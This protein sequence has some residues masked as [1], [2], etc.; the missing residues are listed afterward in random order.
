MSAQLRLRTL[1][2]LQLEHDGV[3]VGGG[4]GRRRPL[5]L[6]A[7]VAL[8]GDAG[9]TRDAALATFWPESSEANARNSLK[10]VV[11]GLRRDLGAGLFTGGATTLR[12]DRAVLGV[13]ALDFLDAV[14]RDEHD[15]AIALYGGAFLD[16]IALHG[17]GALDAWIEEHRS[18]F[19]RAC[20]HA[21]EEVAERARRRGDHLAAVQAW[22]R[23][24]AME[25]L[26]ARATI[27]LVR[28]LRDAGDPSAALDQCRVHEVLV[29]QELDAAPDPAVVAL[30]AEIRAQ[31]EHSAAAER[32]QDGPGAAEAG[33]VPHLVAP[34]AGVALSGPALTVGPML[35][36]SS[37]GVHASAPKAASRKVSRWLEPLPRRLHNSLMIAG[38]LTAIALPLSSRRAVAKAPA[39][40]TVSR[41]LVA[42]LPFAVRGQNGDS[43]RIGFGVADLLSIA[44]HGAGR[45]RSVPPATLLPVVAAAGEDGFTVKDA[46]RIAAYF[47]AARYVLGEVVRDGP[48]LHVTA[49]LHDRRGVVLSQASADGMVGQLGQVTDRLAITLLAQQ[50]LSPGERLA[51]VA[52]SSTSSLPALKAWLDGEAAYGDHRYADAVTAFQSA[53]ADDPGFALALYRLANALDLL[54]EA[55]RADSIAARAAALSGRL[56]AAERELLIAWR[57]A[58]AGNVDEAERLFEALL[59]DEPEHVEGW[60]RLGELQFHANPARGRS[61]T[62]ARRA[63]EQVLRI[64]PGHAEAVVYLA[65]IA[66][67][68]RRMRD[69]DSLVARA[70]ALSTDGHVL[71][72]RAVRTFALG[73]G[74]LQQ[75]A[76]RALLRDPRGAASESAIDVAIYR[77]DVDGMRAFAQTLLRSEPS[78]EVRV[79]AL[80]LEALAAA[81]HGQTAAAESIL[82]SMSALDPASAL[83]LRVLLRAQPFLQAD[84]AGLRDAAARIDAWPSS[85]GGASQDTSAAIA[86]RHHRRGLLAALAG[87]DATLAR[88][89]AVLRAAAR[90]PASRSAAGT[91]AASLSARAALRA[92]RPD[93][94]LRALDIARLVP[95]RPQLVTTEVGD[96][97]LR[98]ELLHQLGRDDEAEGW[99]S[100]IA[101]RAG[102][103]LPWLAPAQL[104]LG[105]IHERRG[106]R[107]AALTHY[108]RFLTLWR[109]CDRE[110]RPVRDSVA[111]T[112]ARLERDV[113]SARGH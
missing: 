44:L 61:V 67:L 53:V 9:V 98:A 45:L 107:D 54:G 110:L 76:L 90:E 91:L 109:D 41:S 4:A 31:L 43:A 29:R 3:A 95:L 21:L 48:R 108:R 82:D 30:A 80:R 34:N 12:V 75:R 63:F 104:R 72:L 84:P 101:E 57:D 112:V 65:R 58:T 25:P 106:Q 22:R 38:A 50:F 83:W 17:L 94:A 81:A 14:A 87:D 42:V 40:A 32:A 7:F 88:E 39:P 68:Q 37:S 27:G 56:P 5:A 26:S 92:G 102:F 51:H 79:L 93:A 49:S 20:A 59:D 69:A 96:R 16:G 10:Q 113:R 15:A 77:D 105:E 35:P 28:S 86:L 64:D 46:E 6:L 24:T 1:G 78:R 55:A 74:L 62:G 111:R 73:E 2:G 33:L 70:R 66:S 89:I 18:R 23:R 97:F 100:A 103:E 36:V 60:F 19:A 47:G 11:F 85:V 8:H 52:A 99:Y 71:E 13:D